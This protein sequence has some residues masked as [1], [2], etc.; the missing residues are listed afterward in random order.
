MYVEIKKHVHNN[1]INMD[2]TDTDLMNLTG[3]GNNMRV[4]DE[5]NMRGGGTLNFA[6]VLTSCSNITFNVYVN[7]NN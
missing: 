1:N 5:N 6:P 2:V 4:G 7:K 3:D